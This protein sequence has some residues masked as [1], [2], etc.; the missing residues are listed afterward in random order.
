MFKSPPP[1]SLSTIAQHNNSDP[2]LN[3]YDEHQ[4]QNLTYS[5]SNISPTAVSS[6][7]T[8]AKR[9]KNR[10]SLSFMDRLLG[11]SKG[12]KISR[13]YDPVHLTHVGFD[14]STGEFIELPKEWQKLL[15]NSGITY[16]EQE[17][18]PQAVMEV[19]K[20]YQ[21]THPDVY[22]TEPDSPYS[23]T[24]SPRSPEHRSEVYSQASSY[25]RDPPSPPPH[26]YGQPSYN[27]RDRFSPPP[28]PP[29]TRPWELP[30]IV[31]AQ[32]PS[33]NMFDAHGSL[34]TKPSPARPAQSHDRSNSEQ[35]SSSSSSQPQV[36]RS[37]SQRN[38]APQTK[39]IAHN[40]QRD[41][42]D[43]TTDWTTLAKP[44]G[45]LGGRS[46][47]A[48]PPSVQPVTTNQQPH[49]PNAITSLMTISEV[50]TRLGTR[51]C[52]DLND[53]L[54]E[55]SCSKYPISNGGYGD[56]YRAKLR[57]G[58]EVAIKT[59]RLLLDAEGQKHVKVS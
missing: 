27:S 49:A 8:F 34:Q 20:F 55:A 18:N 9:K 10:L 47:V 46:N 28:A 50:V 16:E 35:I 42:V 52:P 56:V 30:P 25:S 19:V 48:P 37:K 7:T 33:L 32:G 58:T 24:D 14:P 53:Q 43:K 17:R 6:S 59:M 38:A 41:R 40:R 15:S 4:P 3:Y 2:E 11:A 39:V 5:R 13:P 12:S 26:V 57:D 44:I 23:Q 21:E 29:P 36:I 31:S 45:E 54:D 22:G 1:R 51:G